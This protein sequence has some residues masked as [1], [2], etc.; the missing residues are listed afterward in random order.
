M[1]STA[2]GRIGY[3]IS[4]RSRQ[5][6]RSSGEIPNRPAISSILRDAIRAAST[7]P[8]RVF[9]DLSSPEDADCRSSRW[10]LKSDSLVFEKIIPVF[11]IYSRSALKFLGLCGSG[12]PGEI[13]GQSLVRHHIGEIIAYAKRIIMMRNM[14]KSYVTLFDYRFLD[15][16]MIVTSLRWRI[17]RI[18]H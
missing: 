17:G 9:A 6:D 14:R 3:Q 11:S 7:G 12:W 18:W 8:L 5:Y 15:I 13:P 4:N 16:A 1:R 10:P 2:I